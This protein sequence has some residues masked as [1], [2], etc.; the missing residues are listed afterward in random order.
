MIFNE[1]TIKN[2]KNCSLFLNK[3]FSS[4]ELFN[5]IYKSPTNGM[6]IRRLGT[7]IRIILD[8]NLLKCYYTN[9]NKQG[10]INKL[11]ISC[12]T[13]DYNNNTIID[14]KDNINEGMIAYNFDIIK[15]LSG[16][17]III[18]GHHVN[19]G[20]EWRKYHKNCPDCNK[21]KTI[22]NSNRFINDR[23]NF[24]SPDEFCKCHLNG[25]YIINLENKSYLTKRPVINLT[26]THSNEKQGINF[27]TKLSIVYN[28]T[29]KKYI[30]FTRSNIKLG[31]RFV[32][33]SL[34]KDLLNWE[35]FKYINVKSYDYDKNNY[36]L[37]Y[38]FNYY[39]TYISYVNYAD[40]KKDIWY[41]SGIKVMYS[42]DGYSLWND[43]DY[44]YKIEKSDH[45]DT[46]MRQIIKINTNNPNYD[47]IFEKYYQCKNSNSTPKVIS[48]KFPK[49]SIY[50]IKNTDINNTSEFTIEFNLNKKNRLIAEIEEDGFITAKFDEQEFKFTNKDKEFIINS[51][52]TQMC[53]IK[54]I[55]K[56]AKLFAII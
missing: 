19:K 7:T 6:T 5:I 12:L 28:N 17:Q 21:L 40:V 22:N 25:C 52:I 33:Y 8:N 34:S 42:Q 56:K 54:F 20:I 36:Y 39:D 11:M 53:N 51:N 26:S 23:G 48:H 31:T 37:F 45:D 9:F 44:F 1:Y 18:G 32:S 50:G 24:I 55:F 35:E 3:N 13:Y 46:N 10:E 15:D 30:I 47:E 14:T 27:D 4:T 16:N 43:I 38:C 49:Y 2:K 29:I 41:N